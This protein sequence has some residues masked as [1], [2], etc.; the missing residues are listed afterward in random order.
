M[1]RFFKRHRALG[2]Y[3][4]RLSGELSGRFGR[5]HYYSVAEV[6]KAAQDRNFDLAFVAYA[7]AM[8]CSRCDFDAHYTPLH[9]ACTYDGLRAVVA[10][11][12]FEDATGFDAVNVLM[13]AEAPKDREYAFSQN[14]EID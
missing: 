5:K 9:V 6:S 10:R 1:I 2:S 12:F 13:R 4:W 14:A 3:F 11:R 7:H 8:F